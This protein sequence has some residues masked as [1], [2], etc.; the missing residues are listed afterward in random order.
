MAKAML[1]KLLIRIVK[2]CL[3]ARSNMMGWWVAKPGSAVATEQANQGFR[4]S[5]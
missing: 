3:Q 1:L 4:L 5:L 2:L